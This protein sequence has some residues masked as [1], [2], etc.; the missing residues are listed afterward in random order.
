MDERR[1]EEKQKKERLETHLFGQQGDKV[2][3]KLRLDHL[4]HMLDLC[5]LTAVYQLIQRQQLLRAGPA[6]QNTTGRAQ[7]GGFIASD[8][9]PC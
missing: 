2:A 9:A 4:H 3:L 6:L 8:P 7:K 5:G 1:R